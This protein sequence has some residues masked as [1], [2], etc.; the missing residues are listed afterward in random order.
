MRILLPA[1]LIVLLVLVA[2]SPLYAQETKEWEFFGGYSLQRTQV[3]EY[4]KSTPSIYSIKNRLET[5]NG[6]EFSVTENMNH[7]FGG[8]FDVSGHYKTPTLQGSP[9]QERMHS[10]MYGPRF[11]LHTPYVTPFA[12]VLFGAA[13]SNVQVTPVGP[14]ASNT[15][16]AAAAGGGVD[17]NLG[18]TISVR[19]LQAEYV[20]ADA[21]GASQN[22]YRASAG[23]V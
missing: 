22:N 2:L 16:F 20:H 6:W 11:S 15:S 23:V 19:L 8:T 10:F 3:R 5:L 9:N 1:T 14:H 13:I 17:L 4:F 7:W 18:Q 21:L 12:H